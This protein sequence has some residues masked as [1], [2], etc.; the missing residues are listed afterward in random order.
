MNK[1]PNLGLLM[2]A[3][4][5]VYVSGIYIS[6]N[7][8][9]YCNMAVDDVA[10]RIG[11]D[12]LGGMYANDMYDFMM[13]NDSWFTY[14]PSGYEEYEKLMIRGY[15]VV[16]SQKGKTHGHVVVCTPGLFVKSPKWGN[17]EVPKCMNIGT[18][19]TLDKG[20]NWAFKDP[21]D[22]FILLHI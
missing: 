7:G 11:Y 8:E 17:I 13:E 6:R 10:K 9:T 4:I 3:I 16:A 22:Y 21:P 19:Y 20:V 15:L 1:Y 2:D 12:G 5:G 18:S 14:L